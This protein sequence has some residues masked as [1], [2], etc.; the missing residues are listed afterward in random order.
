MFKVR[1]LYFTAALSALLTFA[2]VASAKYK[3]DR[4]SIVFH[5]HGPGGLKIDGK[6]STLKI[7]EDDKSVTFKTYMNTLDTGIGKRN[8][9]MQ[10]RFK[11]SD[12]PEITLTVSKDKIDAHKGGTVPGTLNF[13]G[14]SK[15]VNVTYKVDGKHIDAS[16]GFNVKDYGITDDDVCELGVC[17]KPDVSV[18]VSFD[19]GEG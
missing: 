10:K 1:S 7:S 16:F 12:Y 19:L 4:P 13:H 14:K 18:D 15:S 11:A 2:A 8:D 9:H 17:A 5:A 3:V 6:S